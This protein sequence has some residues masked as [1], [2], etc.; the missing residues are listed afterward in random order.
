MR[1]AT[2]LLCVLLAACPGPAVQPDAGVVDAGVASPDAGA[3]SAD[4]G[5][6]PDEPSLLFERIEPDAGLWF[7]RR[8]ADGGLSERLPG[9]LHGERPTVSPDRTTI[10]FS[11][12]DPADP[13]GTPVVWSLQLPSGTPTRRSTSLQAVELEPAFS[14]DGTEVLFMSQAEDP[15]GDIVR[16]SFRDG[17]LEDLTNLTPSVM[18]IP[19]RTPAWSPD[20]QRIVF[21]S[22][23]AGSPTVWLMNRDGTNPTQLTRGGNHGDFSPSWSPDG[24]TIAFH[25][26]AGV[27]S[28]I[29][30][31][32]GLVA[33]DGGAP[34]FFDLPGRVY[35]A[36]FSPDGQRLAA[37]GRFDNGTEEDL[38]LITLDGGLTRVHTGGQE[39]HP[40]WW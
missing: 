29:S 24:H 28:T 39:R 1:T 37:W 27:G 34:R 4:A 31:Q 20:G 6:H 11:A 7:V 3:V 10:L 8:F 15:R 26:V 36:R 30:S 14:P 19:D 2:F 22:Y 9:P 38:A 35:D 18:S 16:A 25:R 13:L 17:G 21:T 23:R 33:L 5:V 40:T 32:V 12:P